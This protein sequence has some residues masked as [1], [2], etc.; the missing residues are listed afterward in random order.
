[1][2]SAIII[3]RDAIILVQSFLLGLI[4]WLLPWQRHGLGV[5][6]IRCGTGDRTSCRDSQLAHDCE[7]ADL[8]TQKK[9]RAG[10]P[11]EV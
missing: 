1:L 7:F 4:Y 5:L 6:V 9:T 3:D 2:I 8:T 11:Q 10:R